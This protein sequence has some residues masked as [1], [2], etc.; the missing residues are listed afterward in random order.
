MPYK[1]TAITQ[2]NFSHPI[3][4][5]STVTSLCIVMFCNV[6]LIQQDIKAATFTEAFVTCGSCMWLELEEMHDMHQFHRL[7][8]SQVEELLSEVK[9]TIE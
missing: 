2:S 1:I 9:N 8:S 7:R 6:L 4:S 3:V 5:H